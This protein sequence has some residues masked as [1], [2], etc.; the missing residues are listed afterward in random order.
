MIA[1]LFVC[2]S[3]AVST[4]SNTR[5]E[6]ENNIEA[7]NDTIRYYQDKNGNLVA[8]KRAFESDIKTLKILNQDLYNQIKNLKAKGNVTTATYF[9]GVI[10]NPKQDTMY[11]VSHDT[12]SKGFQRDFAFNNDYRTLEGNVTYRNDTVGVNIDKDQVLFDYVIA[13]DDKNNIMIKSANPYVKFNEMTG[14]QLPHNKQKHWSLNAFS[15]F[16]YAPSNN[17]RFLDIGIS[18]DYKMKRLSVGPMIFYEHNF[19]SKEKS[20]YVGASAN[21]SILEW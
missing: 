17:D 4:C 11:V 13:L 5:L 8:T 6:Y 10:D 15:K 3:Q 1:V 2:I 12:I 18:L 21:L 14:F 7:L 16:G 9:S 19:L 20:V